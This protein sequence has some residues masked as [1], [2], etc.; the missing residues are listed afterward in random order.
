MMLELSAHGSK[1]L[2]KRHQYLKYRQHRDRESHSN[3]QELILLNTS[4][5]ESL[6]LCSVLGVGSVGYA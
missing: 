6:L 3:F 1:V 2:S 5:V 4:F